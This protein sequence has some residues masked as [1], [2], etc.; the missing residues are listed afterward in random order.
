MRAP[1]TLS[2]HRNQN[3]N[4]PAFRTEEHFGGTMTLHTASSLSR[5]G[6]PAYPLGSIST[7]ATLLEERQEIFAAVREAMAREPDSDCL[8]ACAWLVHHL[9]EAPV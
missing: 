3:L 1:K 2:A 8:A 5:S 7:A 9:E 6:L 4:T